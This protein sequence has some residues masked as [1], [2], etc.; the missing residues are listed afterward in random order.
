MKDSNF[1]YKEH[2]MCGGPDAV[3]LDRP[4]F[5][6]RYCDNFI[7]CANGSDED[8]SIIQCDFGSI[9]ENGCCKTY[10][11]DG[12]DYVYGGINEGRDYF[13]NTNSKSLNKHLVFYP[14]FGGDRWFRATWPIEEIFDYI[15]YYG[16]AFSDAMCPPSNATWTRGSAPKCKSMGPIMTD[17]CAQSDCHAD[18]VCINN[19]ES[20]TCKC[21]YGFV[22]DGINCEAL[23]VE[24]ECATGNNL[25]DPVGGECTD[26]AFG[27]ECACGSGFWDQIPD[28]PGQE[29]EYCCQ[30]V[31]LVQKNSDTVWNSCKLNTDLEPL[32]GDKWV[33][34]CSDGIQLEYLA[35]GNWYDWVILKFAEDRLTFTWYDRTTEMGSDENAEGRCFPPSLVFEKNYNAV[36]TSRVDHCA[37]SNCHINAE[38]E[39]TLDSFICSCKTGF[40]GDGV[41][42]CDALPVEN[43]C[44]IGNNDCD[45]IGGV[46]TDTDFSYTCSCDTGFWDVNPEYPGRECDGCCKTVDLIYDNAVYTTCT[47]NT[48]TVS[49]GGGK[50][51]YECDVND[52]HLEYLSSEKNWIDSDYWAWLTWSDEGPWITD[53]TTE[54]GSDI[55]AEGRCFP[56]SLTFEKYFT[57]VCKSRVDDNM[58]TPA[59]ITT[60]SPTSTASSEVPVLTSTQLAINSTVTE[61]GY[62]TTIEPTTATNSLTTVEPTTVTDSLTTVLNGLIFSESELKNLTQK[63]AE[64]EFVVSDQFEYM[65]EMVKNVAEIEKRLDSM[66]DV[67]ITTAQVTTTSTSTTTKAPCNQTISSCGSWS[68]WSSSSSCSVTCGKGLKT[69]ERCFEF[70]DD[71]DKKCE[72]ETKTCSN[73]ACPGWAKWSI[74]GPCSANCRESG[75][76]SPTQER[77]RCWD[78]KTSVGVDCGSGEGDNDYYQSESRDCNSD[79]YCQLDCEWQEWGEWSDCNPNCDEGIKLRRRT[80]N[81]DQGASCDPNDPSVENQIC[82][83]N[84]NQCETCYNLYDRCDRIPISFCT[85]FRFKTKVCLISKVVFRICY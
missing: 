6:D 22:G 76:N 68:S 42:N 33:Y 37:Q 55:D 58:T 46:C 18:A 69:R 73:K 16:Y 21:K 70:T 9:T 85:D 3:G 83:D 4:V 82:S 2:L 81:E 27:Y 23:P 41:N 17:H 8:G 38:C 1:I 67:I 74:W 43:E 61:N 30:T 53:R 56:P 35:G 5:V 13:N 10:V 29:C 45:P 59:P 34:E 49:R 28:S 31:D 26:T 15:S 65:N 32:T 19:L 63:L 66:R 78:T 36:C 54:T 52:A 62:E 77:Y 64:K 60:S 44:V 7:D 48:D 14:Y 72:T 12:E 57:A 84:P 39:N 40:G 20:F 50:W 71:I 25:C 80:N 79:K 51:V 47:L 11:M 75:K 24:D